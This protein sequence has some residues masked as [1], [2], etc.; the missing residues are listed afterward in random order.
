MHKSFTHAVVSKTDSSEVQQDLRSWQY[1]PT[2]FDI[3]GLILDRENWSN[4]H[5]V[6]IFWLDVNQT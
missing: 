6:L 1:F 4:I 2:G 5:S 3:L